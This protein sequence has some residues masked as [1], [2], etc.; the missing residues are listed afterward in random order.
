MVLDVLEVTPLAFAFLFS[1]L[2]RLLGLLARGKAMPASAS[3]PAICA[4]GHSPA[5]RATS[6]K[7][8][9]A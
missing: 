1:E 5:C 3:T 8:C 2:R 9:K 6:C 7:L 4:S